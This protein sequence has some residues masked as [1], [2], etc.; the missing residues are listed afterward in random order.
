MFR[1]H[2]R[3]CAGGLLLLVGLWPAAGWSHNE[4]VHQRMT[5]Y[6]YHALLAGAGFAEGGPMS[7]RLRTALGQLKAADPTITPFFAAAS[8]SRAKLRALRSGLLFDP[9]PCLG[10]PPEVVAGGLPDW[11]LPAAATLADQPMAKVRLPVT[12]LYGHGAVICA[13]DAG[14]APN[15][16]LA[17]VNT[18]TLTTRD[19]TG[20]T[21]GYWAASP[22]K[23]TED[24]ILRSTTLAALQNPVV[25]ANVGINTTVAV[26]AACVLACGLFPP[27]C[28]ACPVLAVVA[29]GV[30]IDEISSIDA[31]SLESEDYVGFGHFVDM[32]P[33]P[34]SPAPFDDKPGKFMPRAGPNGLPD[35]IED[36]VTM[37][38]DIGGFH[39][40]HEK[41]Q[42]PKNYEI[43]LGTSGAIGDDFHRNSTVRT[44][45]AWQ[46]S[47]VPH[48]QLTSVDNL[49]MHG[50]LNAKAQRG[51]A[52]EA[53]HL[54]WPLHALGD[55]T[56]PMHAVGASGYGHRPYEDSVDAGFDGLTGAGSTLASVKTVVEVIKRAHAWRQFI[57]SWRS[58]HA[59]TEVPVRDLIEAVAAKTRT[60]SNATASVFKA[61]G[62]LAYLVDKDAAIALYENTP[63]AAIQRN[64]LL[65]G[66]AAELAFLIA[67]TEVAP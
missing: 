50:Y 58:A 15:G 4:S 32:K 19:H 38:F 11:Q 36:L 8:A 13:I 20:V 27:A 52:L 9:A 24:W 35:P 64:L 30:V 26:S 10:M 39:V 43:V 42:A 41:S 33:V 67:M 7:G 25:L 28:A 2:L 62:S 17:T 37:V 49:A 5:D 51:T 59:S 29:A 22:D 23:E 61:V 66:I 55:A 47:T 12:H 18:G 31:S 21:L 1:I 46:T 54:G 48:T 57:Q 6:A 34:A 14:Y 53:R 65:E 56:V 63:M 40:N 3:Q 44:A 16:V 60:T 45:S